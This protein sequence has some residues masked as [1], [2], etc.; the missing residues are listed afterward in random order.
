MSRVI[1]FPNRNNVK[2]VDPLA[3]VKSLIQE[4]FGVSLAE[5]AGTNGKRSEEVQNK[6]DRAMQKETLQ[7]ASKF[8]NSVK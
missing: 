4:R 3:D 1:S 8:L 5:Y 2:P 7:L 6:I